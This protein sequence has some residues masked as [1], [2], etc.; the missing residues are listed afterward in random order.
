MQWAARRRTLYLSAVFIFLAVV[1]GVPLALWLYDPATCSDGVQNQGETMPDKGGP[2]ALLDERSLIPHSV[3][4]SRS[5]PV[6]GGAYN[7]VAYIE[8]PN[9]EAGVRSANYRFRLYDT[10]NVIIAEKEGSTFIMPGEV[11]PVFDGPFSTGERRVARTYFEFSAPLVWERMNGTSRDI[12]V[13]NERMEQMESAPRISGVAENTSVIDRKNVTFI[14]VVFDAAG[15]ALAASRT[16][17][18]H[19]PARERRDIVF[20]WPESFER[21]AA[22]VD[23]TVVSA[24]ISP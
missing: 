5:F 12:R 13:L 6:R 9:D 18:E 20:T 1:I 19:L 4:W 14:A 15:N 3:E 21:P 10:E 8:N 11:T 24:P 16:L 23:I 22:R 2:C 7:A 17:V